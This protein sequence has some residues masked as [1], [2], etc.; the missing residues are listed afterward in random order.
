MPDDHIPEQ[1]FYGELCHGKPTVGGQRKRYKDSLKVSLKGFNTSTESWESLASDRPSWHHL[2]T[3]GIN[4]AEE[5]RT[6]QAEQRRAARK[7]RA[8]STASTTLSL[9]F[10]TCGRGFFARI[11]LISYFRTYQSSPTN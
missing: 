7:A 2:I 6:L 3:K 1:L 8:T 4:T 11:G 9:Y 10:P 5:G